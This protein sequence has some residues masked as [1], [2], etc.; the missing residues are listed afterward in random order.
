MGTLVSIART[1]M[2]ADAEGVE[3]AV[4]CAVEGVCDIGALARGRR[5]LVKPNVFAPIPAPGTTDPR[6]VAAIV[7]LA[8]SAGAKGVVVGEGRSVSTAR[9]RPVEQRSTRACF[10]AVEMMRAAREAGAACAF[11]EEGKWRLVEVGGEVLRTAE[12]AEAVL[13]C[14]VLINAPVLKNHSLTLVTLCVKNL[15]GVLSDEC[16][17]FGHCYDDMRLARKLADILMIRKPDLNILDATRG[18]EADHAEGDA[19]DVGAVVAGVD[20]V[21]VDAVASALMGLK[22]QE[23]DTTRIAHGRGLGEGDLNR[24]EVVGARVEDVARTFRRPDVAIREEDFPGLRRYGQP[25]CHSCEYYIRRGLDRAK[26]E[27]CFDAARPVT[28]VLG[29]GEQPPDDVKGKVIAAGPGALG[30]EWVAR[31]RPRLEREGRFVA[32][33]SLPPMEFRLRAPALL[34]R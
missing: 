14:D 12:V 21:A 7:R 2:P 8:L 33:E 9:Y 34:G 6:V 26:Q 19:V 27:G 29:D 1:A 20:A 25:H 10:E 24:I 32:L 11:F 22:A 5:V 17:M 18:M 28:L 3:R 31:M 4:N 15:H 16:K 13:D 23:V 30:S